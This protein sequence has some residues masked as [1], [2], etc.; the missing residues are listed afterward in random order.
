MASWLLS[1]AQVTADVLNSVQQQI[2]QAEETAQNALPLT[3][4]TMSGVINMNQKRITNLALPLTAHGAARQQEFGVANDTAE[5]ALTAANALELSKQDVNSNLTDIAALTPTLGTFM[6]GNSTSITTSLLLADDL[7][8]NLDASKFGSGSVLSTEYNN[9]AGA[10]SSIQNQLD[11]VASNKQPVNSKLTAISAATPTAGN[12][13]RGNGSA[14]VSSTIQASDVPPLIDATRVASGHVTNAEFDCLDGVT[15]NIQTQINNRVSNTLLGAADGVATLDANGRLTASQIPSSLSGIIVYQGTWNAASNTPQLNDPPDASTKGNYYVVSVAGTQFGQSWAVDDWIVSSGTSWKKIDNQTLVSSVFG[16]TGA[17]TAQARDYTASQVSNT[18]SN[19]ITKSNVQDA[20]NELD[21]KKL[22]RAGG[23][24]IGGLNM[25]MFGITNLPAP[26]N[27]NDAAH[28]AYVDT[29]QPFNANLTA[30]SSAVA[31]TGHYLRGN[32]STY[33]SS[34]ILSND[35]PSQ[36]DAGKFSTNSVSNTEFGYL[37]DVTAPIQPQLTTL[38]TRTQWMS[39]TSTVL[40]LNSNLNNTSLTYNA[41][42]PTAGSVVDLSGNTTTMILP[43]GTTLERP[44]VGI[45]GMIRYNTTRNAFEGFTGSSWGPFGAGNFNPIITNPQVGDVLS[46]DSANG[47]WTNALM[48]AQGPPTIVVN[49][50]QVTITAPQLLFVNVTVTGYKVQVA[51]DSSFSVLVYDSPVQPSNVFS[52]ALYVVAGTTYYVRGV[53]QTSFNNKFTQYSLTTTYVAPDS[54]GSYVFANRI[55]SAYTDQAVGDANNAGM[56]RDGTD[57]VYQLIN[58]NGGPLIVYNGNGGFWGSVAY[59]NTTLLSDAGCM[60]KYNAAGSVQ[61]YVRAACDA[62]NT[63]YGAR[64]KACAVDSSNNVYVCLLYD[65]NGNGVPLSLL[66]SDGQSASATTLSNITPAA[67]GMCVVVIMFDS[68]GTMQRYCYINY[69]WNTTKYADVEVV[70]ALDGTSNPYIFGYSFQDTLQIRGNNNTADNYSPS[71]GRIGAYLVKFN[72]NDFSISWSCC[73]L[74]TASGQSVNGSRALKF[75]SSNNPVVVVNY[76]YDCIVANATG[77]ILRTINYNGGGGWAKAVLLFN[78]STGG[79]SWA[80]RIIGDNGYAVNKYAVDSNNAVIVMTASVTGTSTVYR[81]D[82]TTFANVAG[83]FIVKYDALGEPVWVVQ[84]STATLANNVLSDTTNNN[85]IKYI[86]SL[87]LNSSNLSFTNAN[88]TPGPVVSRNG[89][90]KIPVI[91]AIDADGIVQWATKIDSPLNANS[92]VVY[93]LWM[94]IDNQHNIYVGSAFSTTSALV[95]RSDGTLFRTISNDSVTGG[96]NS[97]IVSYTPEG[98]VRW[99]NKQGSTNSCIVQN[100]V[101]YTDGDVSANWTYTGSGAVLYN[102][103]SNTVAITLPNSGVSDIA[104]ARID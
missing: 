84:A 83:G 23:T 69:L 75:D 78:A 96:L 11:A 54:S 88:A 47:V 39:S 16:R 5:D 14:F 42:A 98:S 1:S 48:P 19:N 13:L 100:L 45:P 104:Y 20:L 102:A 92:G 34:A 82:G 35:L 52:I 44:A 71:G 21:D 10:S 18:P 15:S 30:I 95:Y 56:V 61:W 86:L 26:T 9:L 50:N 2:Y 36:I 89:T 91:F 72:N 73:M 76:G 67:L 49:N 93:A 41:D 7:P 55:A 81:L 74:S 46:Y 63:G 77:I 70:L 64:M 97:A 51:T 40:T 27:A 60:I 101:L 29:K 99:T 33:A 59:P 37:S 80:Q 31:T 87:D 65:N 32:G 68:A 57:S 58:F 85:N 43:K 25:N 90:V 22:S 28:K 6:R 17:V 66:W 94:S 24:M 3:G 103:D 53:V 12:Y 8:S 79:V 62:P 4:G 38:T